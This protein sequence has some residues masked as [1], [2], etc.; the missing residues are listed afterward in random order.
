MPS[1][2]EI[3]HDAHQLFGPRLRRHAKLRLPGNNALQR[4]REGGVDAARIV[5]ARARTRVRVLLHALG[6]LFEILLEVRRFARPAVSRGVAERERQIA[7]LLSER[8]GL[9]PVLRLRPPRCLAKI[10]HG[11]M[12]AETH[13]H[14]AHRPRRSSRA[15][16][17]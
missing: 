1:G 14:R 2:A 13:P 7:K 4:Q 12:R 6:E 15:S 10:V 9:L 8:R 3:G 11:D 5:L 17:R 16:A